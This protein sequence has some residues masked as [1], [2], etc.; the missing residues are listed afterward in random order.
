V[1]LEFKISNIEPGGFAGDPCA[2]DLVPLSCPFRGC[3]I[4]VVF[5]EPLACC[6]WAMDRTI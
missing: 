6:L 3:P 4:R 1:D 2:S 5:M